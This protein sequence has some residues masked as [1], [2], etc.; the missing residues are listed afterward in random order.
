MLV[1][2]NSVQAFMACAAH[3]AYLAGL[4]HRMAA[5]EDSRLLRR[6]SRRHCRHRR[7]DDRS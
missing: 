1:K 7:T 2:Q 4:G 5:I 6:W 3:D